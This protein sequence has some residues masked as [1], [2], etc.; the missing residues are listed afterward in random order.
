MGEVGEWSGG[1]FY[2]CSKNS[3]HTFEQRW[4]GPQTN[5]LNSVTPTKQTQIER[6]TDGRPTNQTIFTHF[7]LKCAGGCRKV[8]H[9]TK[10][11]EAEGQCRSR[12]DNELIT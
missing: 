11:G 1:V 6:R 2:S 5:K 9:A 4:P 7:V 3:V 10:E 8:V 12:A